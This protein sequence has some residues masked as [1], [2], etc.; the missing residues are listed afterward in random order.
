MTRTQRILGNVLALATD[1]GVILAVG[2]LAVEVKTIVKL[3]RILRDRAAF[4]GIVST[5]W[6]DEPR[7]ILG[8]DVVVAADSDHVSPAM[9]AKIPGVSR[10]HLYK[11]MDSGDLPFTHVGR[12]R[13]VAFAAIRAFLSQQDE[14]RKS[15]AERLAHPGPTRA[16]AWANY[17]SKSA[18]H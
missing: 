11:V 6:P 10:T 7:Y 8:R 1:P 17:K 15:T 13:R 9:A 5:G 3:R 2:T 4:D 16:T 12:D 14:L 18:R